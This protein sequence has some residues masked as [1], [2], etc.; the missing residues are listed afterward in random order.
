MTISVPDFTCPAPTVH[1]NAITPKPTTN[2]RTIAMSVF[3]FLRRILPYPKLHNFFKGPK[4]VGLVSLPSLKFVPPPP[5]FYLLQKITLYGVRVSSYSIMV[6]PRGVA[7]SQKC[8]RY[9]KI[10]RLTSLKRSKYHTQ[11]PQILGAT[12]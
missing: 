5:H 2:I 7:N 9:I 11:D 3:S 12:I 8:R 1:Q 10:I 6:I 4:S